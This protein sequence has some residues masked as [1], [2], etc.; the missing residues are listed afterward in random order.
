MGERLGA[1]R[2]VAGLT[3]RQVATDIG[4]NHNSVEAWERG[5][6]PAEEIRAQ[7]AALYEVDEDVLFAE[8]A[9]RLGA[10]RDLLRPA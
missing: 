1:A 5:S 2:L 6:V 9:A 8:V 7:L 10:A 3:I 4:V